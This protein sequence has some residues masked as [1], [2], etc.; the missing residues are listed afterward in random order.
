MDRALI[1]HLSKEGM[2]DAIGKCKNIQ[3]QGSSRFRKLA[4]IELLPR[5]N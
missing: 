2:R 1:R 4:C 5:S 3:Y